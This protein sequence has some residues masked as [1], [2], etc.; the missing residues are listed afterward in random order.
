MSNS[1]SR[2]MRA[3]EADGF[4]ASHLRF[5]LVWLLLVAWVL[6]FWLA[7]LTLYVA[8]DAARLEVDRAAH[9]LEAVVGGRVLKSQ[10]AL[11]REVTAGEVLVEI[12]ASDTRLELDTERTRLD[13]LNAEL[14]ELQKLIA[15]EAEVQLKESQ[16]ASAAHEEAQARFR[17]ADGVARFAED[18][19]QRTVRL[20]TD[21]TVSEVE[22][23]RARAEAQK[24][25][26]SADA[27]LLNVTR[28]QRDQ[29][30]RQSERQ[31]RIQELHRD[32]AALKGAIATSSSTMD[33]IAQRMS[34][35]LVRAPVAGRL[36]EVSEIS[37]GAVV[38]Q[39]EK[40]AAII[41]VGD[42]FVVAQLP[43]ASAI[44]RVKTGQAAR[45]RLDAFPWTQYGSLPATVRTV[46][47]E[48]QGGR[49]RVELDLADNS[50]NL[51][52]LEHGLTG[53]L[54]VAVERVSPAMLV[55]R[56]MGALL[57]GRSRAVRP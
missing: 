31:A 27:I 55:M 14:E 24:L 15:A 38:V 39:G 21:G 26:A 23:L 56:S 36:G 37:T 11:G 32:V 47:S 48:V 5:S 46:A 45:V 29:D 8:T 18:E 57:R 17:E 9:P 51:I 25:R 44:G 35:H 6:W 49:I 33:V 30:R 19:E 10:L 54:E 34:E 41:P 50:M 42:L 7:R 40:L 28:L 1:F 13:G 22:L 4:S 2:T 3:L 52:K 20:R 12:D 53:A 43:P 16:A